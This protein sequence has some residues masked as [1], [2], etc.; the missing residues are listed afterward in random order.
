[1]KKLMYCVLVLGVLTALSLTGCS[2]GGDDDGDGGNSLPASS[3]ANELSGK[4]SFHDEDE[5]IEFSASGTYILWE[6]QQKPDGS[7]API[8]SGSK[9]VWIN[10]GTGSYSWNE[11]AKQVFLKPDRIRDEDDGVY[12]PTLMT[13]NEL[14]N[15]WKQRYPGED[16]YTRGADEKFAVRSLDYVEAT[17]GTVLLAWGLPANKGTNE[18]SGKTNIPVQTSGGSTNKGSISFT[19]S[20]FTYT[21][22]NNSAG[23]GYNGQYTYDSTETDSQDSGSFTGKLI[24]IKIREYNGMD[25]KAYYENKLLSVS[26]GNY[27]STTEAAAAQTADKFNTTEGLYNSGSNKVFLRTAW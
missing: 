21:A 10:M 4:T 2:S 24:H 22:Y 11:T 17:D 13:R 3:G 7:G 1:M 6:I 9:Y 16:W 26:E 18:V 15:Y 20:E 8:I 23:T 19:A 12:S 25:M 27:E 5:K 14:I